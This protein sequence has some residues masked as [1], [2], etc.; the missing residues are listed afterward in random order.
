MP[1]PVVA[2]R[3][4]SLQIHE[5]EAERTTSQIPG[6]VLTVVEVAKWHRVEPRTVT[7]WIVTGKLRAYKAGRLWRIPQS[8]VTEFVSAGTI[9]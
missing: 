4:P 7:R 1:A 9:A 3:S 5:A 8:A 2:L 6:P